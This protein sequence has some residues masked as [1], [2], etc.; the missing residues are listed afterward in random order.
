MTSRLS[1]GWVVV[2][3]AA[4]AFA[5]FSGARAQSQEGV[6]VEW[7]YVGADQAHT[8]FSTAAQITLDNVDQL[9]IAWEW[10]PGELPLQEYGTR[11]GSFQTTPL[12]ID[13]ILY[14]STMYTRVVALDVETGEEVWAFDPRAYEGGS[15]GAPRGGFK[16]RGIAVHGEGDDM[17]VFLNSR[18]K[19][20]AIDAKS[21]ELVATFG[22]DGHVVL[23]EGF[24]NDVSPEEFDQTS[25]PVV[26]ED[27]VIVGSRVPDRIQHRF[28]TPGSVQAFDVHTGERR[29]VF[30][31]VPQSNDSF[32]ADTW[33]DGSCSMYRV[34]H[35]AHRRGADLCAVLSH[36][37]QGGEGKGHHEAWVLS[38]RSD[39]DNC[40]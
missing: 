36:P 22:D 5:V 10:E 29:R 38:R 28:D 14:V 33:E 12:M 16:H 24:P 30:Y 26:F 27:L 2:L 1:I 32:G 39:A 8:K 25:P 37:P 9:E 13:N 19:L 40:L 18:D 35:R 20:Y 3:A 31:T 23:T 21:G 11:P 15:R 6:M 34:S 17:R 7:P 4:V